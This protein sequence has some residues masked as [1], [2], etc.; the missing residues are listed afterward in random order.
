MTTYHVQHR[1]GFIGSYDTDKVVVDCRDA[2]IYSKAGA[3]YRAN[4]LNATIGEMDRK[5]QAVML[6]SKGTVRKVHGMKRAR[7]L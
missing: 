4:E 7:G 6:T 2:V 3:I 5:A 1:F